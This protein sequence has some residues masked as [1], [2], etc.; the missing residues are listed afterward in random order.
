LP[1]DERPREKL[2]T[3]GPDALTNA[4]LVALILN[5][6]SQ[7]ESVLTLAQ[8]ILSESGG[9]LRGLARRDLDALMSI[10]GL[11]PAKAVKLAAA[12][13]IGRRL[14]ALTPD[15]RPVVKTPEDLAL[16]FQPGLTMLDHEQ[17][18]V[19]VLDTKHRLERI[20][21]VYRGSVSSAQVRTAEVFR[22][23]VRANC[24]AVAIA[25]NHPSGDPTPSADDIALTAH[26]VNAARTLDIELLDHLII[27]DGRWVSLRR[28]KLGFT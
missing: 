8:R 26:L 22:E 7:G 12:L 2:L 27:G 11:G 1:A 10:R 18:R 3:R 24:P 5:T 23:A 17:L 25:H 4:E 9:G 28:S 16:I 13:E 6:G 20:V 19:A 15:E 21:T 14:G